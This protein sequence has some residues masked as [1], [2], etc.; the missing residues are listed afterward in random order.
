MRKEIL[1]YQIIA[2]II[3]FIILYRIV[4]INKTIKYNDR[5]YIT[6]HFVSTP[7]KKDK[8]SSVVFE[9]TTPR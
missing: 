7:K 1:I 3:L 4:K 6:F 2:A 5:F 8:W 9:N